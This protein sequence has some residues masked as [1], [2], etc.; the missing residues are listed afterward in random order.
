MLPHSDHYVSARICFDP[1]CAVCIT[2]IEHFWKPWLFICILADQVITMHW[3]QHQVNFIFG[4]SELKALQPAIALGFL[5]LVF[6]SMPLSK[7]FFRK[8]YKKLSKITIH[9]SPQVHNT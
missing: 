2:G 1:T 5:A 8:I 7:L 9:S 3:A 6:S 4:Q